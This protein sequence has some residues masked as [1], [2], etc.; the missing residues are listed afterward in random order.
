VII[1]NVPLI[2]SVLGTI[3]IIEPLGVK[4]HRYDHQ[5]TISGKHTHSHTVPLELGGYYRT[6]TMVVGPLLARYKKA[7]VPNPGG[8]RLGKRPIDWHMQ[9]LEKM[10]ASVTYR[11]GYF[12]AETKQLHGATIRFDKN[13]H[14]GTETIILAAVLAQGKTVIENAAAEPEVDDLIAMLNQMGAHITR[15]KRTITIEG[16]PKLHGVSYTVMPDRNEVVTFAIAAIATKGDITVTGGDRADLLAF[17]QALDEVGAGW[18]AIDQKTTRFYW[19]QPLKNM[20]IVTGPY[21]AFMTDWQ[22]PWAVLA[23]QSA[24]VSTIHETVFESRFS[25]VSELKKMGAKIEFYEPHV[26]NPETFYN[27]NWAD[28]ISGFNQGI[29]IYGP[30]PLHEAVMEMT[31]IRA[32]ATLLVAALV[33]NGT[34]VL[35]EVDHMDR[36]YEQLDGRLRT[37]GAKITRISDEI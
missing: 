27:F 2:S 37:L 20:S 7:V 6:A 29:K 35:S 31:D 1:R 5:M 25:Y 9:A 23:T 12:Y 21:P 33:A 18:E 36:G 28:R 14:T 24:G 8:C 19:R 3:K 32:G 10:G 4:V 11:D 22:Q 26:E 13:T 16:V 15:Q 30:T 34:S 17:L